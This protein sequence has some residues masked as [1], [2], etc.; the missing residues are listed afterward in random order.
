[1]ERQRSPLPTISLAFGIIAL[2]AVPFGWYAVPFAV[3]GSGAAL[4]ALREPRGG[5]LLV[6]WA[7]AICVLAGILAVGAWMLKAA[8]EGVLRRPY[9]IAPMPDP[10][11]PTPHPPAS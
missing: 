7:L 11:P 4:I 3:I 2:A 6:R 5:L 10:P 9:H 8:L 1:M